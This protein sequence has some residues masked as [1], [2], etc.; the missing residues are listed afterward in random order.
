MVVDLDQRPLTVA[1]HGESKSLPDAFDIEG[2]IS[3]GL[4]FDMLSRQYTCRRYLVSSRLAK[5]DPDANIVSKLYHGNSLENCVMSLYNAQPICH[6]QARRFTHHGH[7]Q[8]LH[9][10]LR[11]FRLVAEASIV[12]H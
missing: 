1:L 9:D 6:V 11:L 12:K 2:V 7:H 5:A 4:R 10:T 8:A 3:K